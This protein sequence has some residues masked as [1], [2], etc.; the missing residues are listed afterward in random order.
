MK[1]NLNMSFTK[2][3]YDRK[4]LAVFNS[5]GMCVCV[6]IA[7]YFHTTTCDFT[8]IILLCKIKEFCTLIEKSILF[9]VF[10]SYDFKNSDAHKVSTM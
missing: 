2:P 4:L 8:W 10:V 1:V 5:S 6:N 9:L 7:M 3:N